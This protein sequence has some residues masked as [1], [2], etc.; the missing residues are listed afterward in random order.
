MSIV[1]KFLHFSFK[2]AIFQFWDLA[3]KKIA[4]DICRHHVESNKFFALIVLQ[5]LLFCIFERFFIV[6]SLKCRKLSQGLKSLRL[7]SALYNSAY[8]DHFRI[9]V[10]E[11]SLIRADPAAIMIADGPASRVHT[12]V[13][14][15]PQQDHAKP[16]S[17]P[18][19]SR[20]RDTVT[21]PGSL[22]PNRGP[23]LDLN[24]LGWA[25]SAAT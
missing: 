22:A 14:S 24:W 23:E 6:I 12:K 13:P 3:Q 4:I 18:N 15:Y 1:V 17:D 7:E 2:Y 5:S 16:N 9:K 25:S 11:S 20:H 8:D 19:P 21:Y 10:F